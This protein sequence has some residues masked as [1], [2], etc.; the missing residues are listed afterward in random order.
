MSFGF[1]EDS[2]VE[3][4]PVISNA[5]SDALQARNQ[6]II[7]F[8]AAANEGGNQAEMFPAS[9]PQVISVRGTDDKGWSQP[10]NP[11]RGN[12]NSRCIMTLGLDVP[13]AGLNRD[14]GGEVLK[15]GTSVSTPIAAGIAAMALAYARLYEADLE[16]VLGPRAKRVA[17]DVW[18]VAGIYRLLMEMSIEMIDR[19]YYLSA[20][21][22]TTLSHELRVGMIAQAASANMRR[23]C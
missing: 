12:E 13:A 5:I 2:C 8:A 6:R 14:G 20:T 10:F 1:E 11:P 3:G 17:A 18:T 21:K 22:F 9:H 7:F 23:G 19:L 4:M 15:S 16:R